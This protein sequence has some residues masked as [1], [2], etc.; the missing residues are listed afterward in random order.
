MSNVTIG[1]KGVDEMSDGELLAW[2][3]D[4]KGGYKLRKKTARI[5]IAIMRSLDQQGTPMTVRGLFYNCENVYRVVSKS[6]TGYNQVANQVLAMRRAGVLPYSFIADHTRWVRKPTTYTGLQS[7]FEHGRK[8]YRRALWDNQSDYVEVWCEK[9]AI[10]GIL[11]DVTDEWDVPLLVVHGYTSETFA[12]NA[13]ENIKAQDKPAFIYYFGDWDEYGL[14]ISNDIKNK[15]IAFG[16]NVL[17]ERVTVLPWQIEA[18]GLPTRPAKPPKQP[19]NGRR[20]RVSKWEGPCVEVDAVPANILRSMVRE[21]ITRHIDKQVYESAIHAEKL[22]R[23]T[24]NEV[25]KNLGLASNSE[26]GEL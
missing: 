12:Y 14:N 18:L 6:E 11:K 8:A 10:A 3:Q 23:Q 21:N 7:Y 9:D 25:M 15:L 1:S 4:V 16:A 5:W 19:K 24:L 22:E 13:A 2:M 26:R 20:P 17:F